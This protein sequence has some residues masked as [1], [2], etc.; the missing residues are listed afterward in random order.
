LFC[1]G[2]GG[3]GGGGVLKRQFSDL[4]V[5]PRQWTA[6]PWWPPPPGPGQCG[7][8]AALPATVKGTVHSYLNPHNSK[9]VS[10]YFHMYCTPFR[11]CSCFILSSSYAE[12]G[13]IERAG[14]KRTN[15]TL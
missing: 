3:G 8:P 14:T 10:R 12:R 1:C 13:M 2:G 7:S 15:V 6:G 11:T 9:I 4:H 5:R